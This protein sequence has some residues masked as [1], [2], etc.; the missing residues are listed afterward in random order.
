MGVGG[1]GN[2]QS[3]TVINEGSAA[4][5]IVKKF[6]EMLVNACRAGNRPEKG[7]ESADL[8]R[9]GDGAG[10]CFPGSAGRVTILT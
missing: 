10:S 1:V 8:I 6:R 3:E 2:F 5:Q 4:I 9:G 7:P